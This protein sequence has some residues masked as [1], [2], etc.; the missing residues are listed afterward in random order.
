MIRASL[1]ALLTLLPGVASAADRTI[2]VGSFERLRVTGPFAVRVAAGPPRATVSGDRRAIEQVEVRADGNTLVVQMG[3]NRWGEQPGGRAGP[4][5][6][7]L[8]TPTLV[9]AGVS[10]DAEVEIARMK[11]QRVEVS[12]TGGATITLAAVDA[13]QFKLAV[14]GTAT[15]TASGRAAKASLRTNGPGTVKAAALA[16]DELSVRLDGN[17]ATEARAR[18]TADVVN[19]GRGRVTVLGNPRCS[20]KDAVG[21]QVTC[22]SDR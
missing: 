20:I 4:V 16:T 18:F 3:A 7:T 14:I 1:L 13:D 19:T 6:V 2:G 12:A 9:Y 10:G 17:G 8:S 22:R 5:T 21:G 11:G 15:V